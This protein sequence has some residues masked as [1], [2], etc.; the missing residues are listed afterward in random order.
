MRASRYFSTFPAQAMSPYVSAVFVF[1]SNL[2]LANRMARGMVT[3]CA[4]AHAP[5]WNRKHVCG[6]TDG[7]L[8]DYGEIKEPKTRSRIHR[9]SSDGLLGKSSRNSIL[10]LRYTSTQTDRM[11]YDLYSCTRSTASWP[12]VK[13]M[14]GSLDERARK[15]QRVARQNKWSQ[16]HLAKP[17]GRQ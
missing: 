17:Y 4:R 16:L 11:S 15:T 5:G 10:E 1:R 14:N 7:K 2:H 13:Q 12:K 3:C 9:P 6:I 8:I